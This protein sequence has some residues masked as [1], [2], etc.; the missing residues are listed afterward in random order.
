ML[1]LDLGTYIDGTYRT[2][3]SVW[4]WDIQVTPYTIVL[5]QI[6]PTQLSGICKGK[7]VQLR[8]KHE[9]FQMAYPASTVTACPVTNPLGSY[10]ACGS[11]SSFLR[12]A[13]D[14]PPCCLDLPL[15]P[16]NSAADTAKVQRSCKAA[17][18]T[19]VVPSLPSPSR[20]MQKMNI[21]NE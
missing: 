16:F 7:S 12:S 4:I 17:S 2:L 14:S 13:I 6:L 8:H 5:S 19:P 20:R 15:S 21:E 1:H 3:G 18:S 9:V 11:C 10:V